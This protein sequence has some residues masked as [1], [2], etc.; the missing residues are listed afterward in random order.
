MSL[1]AKRS[2]MRPANPPSIWV[3]GASAS[4]TWLICRNR[5]LLQIEA[6]PQMPSQATFLVIVREAPA[7]TTKTPVELSVCSAGPSSIT[8]HQ[9]SAV[10]QLV[11]THV[12]TPRMEHNLIQFPT[13]I[14]QSPQMNTSFIEMKFVPLCSWK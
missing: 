1:S 3:L 14:F 6:V 8:A 9:G 12:H 5:C 10:L 4:S 2:T 7:L 11:Q 13:C